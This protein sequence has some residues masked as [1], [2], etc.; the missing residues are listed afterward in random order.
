[1][2]RFEEVG[3]EMYRKGFIHGYFHT[4][5]GEEGIAAGAC[6]TLRS[7]DYI[8]STHRGHGHCIAKGADIKKMMAEVFGKKTG[9]SRGRGGSM[10]IA[11][12]AT[13]NIGANGIVGGGIPL[14]VG[15]G[16]G[17]KLEHSDRVVVCFFGDGA[18]NSGVFPESLNLAAIYRLPV[19]F[20][21][22]NNCYA[23]TTHIRD[24]SVCEELS[25]RGAGYGVESKTIF[26]ND[27]LEVYRSV[28]TCVEKARSGAGPSFI[29]AMTYRFLGHHINDPGTYMSED[30]T[31]EWRLHDPL[32]YIRKHLKNCE[33]NDSVISS[34]DDEIE[35]K[36]AEAVSFA[37]QS[38]E[39]DVEEFLAEIS[40]YEME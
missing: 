15:V 34:I 31:A 13:G 4:Y 40:M 8:V 25:S 26:G 28:R 9:Y 33:I 24:V 7:D 22:E 37:V 39:P 3:M 1:I 35:E 5:I 32:D 38:P 27:P 19:I 6:C 18:A 14:A 17:I 29:E 2:R 11:D 20:L 10:H 23:S 30:T 16:L 21:L 36:I 12:R